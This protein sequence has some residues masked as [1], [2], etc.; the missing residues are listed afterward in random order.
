MMRP[1][2]E[3]LLRPRLDRESLELWRRARSLVVFEVPCGRQQDRDQ[4]RRAIDVSRSK[5][6]RVRTMVVRGKIKRRG[7]FVGK[8]SNW[9]KAIVTLAEGPGNRRLWGFCRADPVGRSRR[10]GL[11]ATSR[12]LTVSPAPDGFGLRGDHEGLSQKKACLAPSEAYGRPGAARKH[13]DSPQGWRTSA[14][15]S[16]YR[17]Q[18]SKVRCAREGGLR[19]VRPESVRPYRSPCTTQTAR[20]LTFWRP[21]SSRLGRPLCPPLVRSTLWW[22]TRCLSRISLWVLSFTISNSSPVRGASSCAPPE[23]APS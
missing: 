16:D 3:I 9:K 8:R 14:P 11:R 19:R 5:W 13:Y 12:H 18:A 10:W 1:A 21:E 23:A 4:E 7:R 20:R 2:H 22:A 17:F 6:T 15:V